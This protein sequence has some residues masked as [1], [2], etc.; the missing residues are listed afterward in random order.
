[1]D[2]FKVIIEDDEGKRSV[3]PVTLGEVSVG[4]HESSTI[5]LG[6]R[7][8]SRNHLRFFRDGSVVFA[9]D[10]DSYN[11]VFLNGVKI[12][13]RQE[14]FDG[15]IL[16][17]G[18]FHLELKGELLGR[19]QE[20]TTQR[21]LAPSNDE[22][23]PDFVIDPPALDQLTE[24]SSLTPT[25]PMVAESSERA[26]PTAIIRMEHLEG[27]ADGHR[28]QILGGADK[29]KL[30]CVSS[31]YAGAEFELDHTEMV[32]G[33]TPDNA[34]RIDHR[35]V[36]RHHAKIVCRGQSFRVVDLGSANGT[37]VNSEQYAEIELKAFDLI[38][39]GHVKFRFVPAGMAY[40]LTSEERKAVQDGAGS[41]LASHGGI[42]KI[43]TQPGVLVGGGVIFLTLIL[44]FLIGGRDTDPVGKEQAKEAS[45][46]HSKEQGPVST[47]IK[48]TRKMADQK[49]AK[50]REFMDAREWLK[51]KKLVTLFLTNTEGHE[52]EGL[53]MLDEIEREIE[54][55]AN[56][57]ASNGAIEVGDWT[58]AWNSLSE[59]APD[60]A[61]YADVLGLREQVKNQL[62]GDLAR[63]FKQAERSGDKKKMLEV[64]GDIKVLAPKSVQ[65]VELE[66]I[67]RE[68]R[69]SGQAE[70][71]SGGGRK[72]AKLSGS[73]TPLSKAGGKSAE[74]PAVNRSEAKRFYEDGRK[75]M[76]AQDWDGA[77]KEFG[78]CIRVNRQF[79]NCYKATGIVYAQK[80][81]NPRAARYYRLYL[82]NCPSAGD[83]AQV[84][85]ILD[86]Y[87][88]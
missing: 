58:E 83:A 72:R 20:Q 37:L 77:L 74:K 47:Q 27:V 73:E 46:V 68:R 61:Y 4:R 14:I 25:A 5:C 7:N 52:D 32:I 36:S 55:K 26:E 86:L 82:K 44:I 30:I 75:K 70:P 80:G 84:R 2:A 50:A 35:S 15:D 85:Q 88:E 42:P 79:C 13:R 56:F 64:I 57:D 67:Y 28:A 12:D 76:K 45:V 18:D 6:E 66:K 53:S 40:E 11:G 16:R 69:R 31:A 65:L 9:E 59:V 19:N 63:D 8:V 62:V 43:L 71:R 38:E 10:L 78:E 22:T 23:Q 41:T 29:A 17:V 33:R 21:T 48:V 87:E 39:L 24:Q 34:I 49:L 60:S 81:D 54:H 3:V 51:A 1:M